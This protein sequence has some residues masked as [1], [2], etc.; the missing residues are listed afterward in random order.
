MQSSPNNPKVT[1]EAVAIRYLSFRPR[2]STEVE[3]KLAQKAIELGITDPIAIIDEIMTSLK[4]SKFINDEDLLERYI[5]GRL[6]EKVKGPYWIRQK[7]SRYGLSKVV[8]DAALAKHASKEA[9]L[10]A[11]SAYLA[12]KPVPTPEQRQ[13]LIRRLMS[14]GFP[15]ELVARSFDWKPGQE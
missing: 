13:K 6:F 2:F 12:K 7:L 10:T 11:L 1:L 9:Q 14:R 4:N 15:Y 8:I 3:N 5:R